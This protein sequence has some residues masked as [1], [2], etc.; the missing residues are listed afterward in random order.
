M[1]KS[2]WAKV[3]IRI[4][5]G[6]LCGSRVLWAHVVKAICQTGTMGEENLR[7]ELF[8]GNQTAGRVIDLTRT[9]GELVADEPGLAD[10]LRE[11]GFEGVSADKTI[12]EVAREA[13]VGM[14][15]IAFALEASGYDVQGFE[16]D[17]FVSPLPE[18]VGRFF[19]PDEDMPVM[20]EG[21]DSAS[22]LIAHMETAIRH[23]QEE[24]NLPK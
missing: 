14:S 8:M 11:I 13:D 17:G 12:P 9:I 6:L 16:P 23:A 18:I 15:V 5:E 3:N 2:R 20:A 10:S 7:E 4:R 1:S 22:S 19:S 21:T 24:G